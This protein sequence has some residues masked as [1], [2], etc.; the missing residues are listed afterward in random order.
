MIRLDWEFSKGAQ[1]WS[2]VSVGAVSNEGRFRV[3]VDSLIYSNVNYCGYNWAYRIQACESWTRVNHCYKMG[4]LATGDRHSI[5]VGNTTSNLNDVV[6]SGAL[7]FLIP[8]QMARLTCMTDSL[9]NRLA[10]MDESSLKAGTSENSYGLFRDYSGCLTRQIVTDLVNAKLQESVSTSRDG[11]KIIEKANAESNVSDTVEYNFPNAQQTHKSGLNS[12]LLSMTYNQWD[13]NTGGRYAR[14]RYYSTYRKDVSQT[15]WETNWR[16]IELKVRKEQL[17]IVELATD[18]GNTRDGRVL[19]LQRSL[20]LNIEFRRLAVQKVLSNK[21]SK[22]SGVDQILITNDEPSHQHY[23]RWCGVASLQKWEI[24]EWMRNVIHN[25]TTYQASPVKRVYIPKPNGKKR[26][27]GIPTIRDRCL[28]ALINFV[29]EP[30]VEMKSDRHSYG[31]R[32]YRSAKMAIGALRVNLRSAGEFYDKYALDADIKGFFDN[33]SHDWLMENTPLETTLR[34]ILKQWLKA[35]HIYNGEWS[36]ATESGTPQGG[37]ISPTLANLTLNGLEERVEKSIEQIYNVKKRGI[38]L[39]KLNHPRGKV[40][41]GWLSTNLFVVRFADD[42]VILARSRRM[43]EE[44]IKP[45]VDEFLKER[46]L[47]L[48]EE[49]TKIVS[50][51]EGDKLDFLGYTLRYLKEIRPKSKL[52]HDRQNKE[53]IVCYPQKAKVQ[54]IIKKIRNIVENSYSITAYSLISKLNPVIRG[55]CQYFNLGQSYLF[56]NKLNYYLY[57]LIQKWAR[58]KHPRWGRR[59]IAQTYFLD[60]KRNKSRL[61]ETISERTG[62]TNKWIFTGKTKNESIHR[63]SKGGKRI[64]LVNPTQ[65]TA[66]LSAKLNR[67]P[68]ELELVHAYHPS[69]VRL[70]E[71][72]TKISITSLKMNQ[73]AKL[74]LFIKQKGKC[75]MCGETLLDEEGEFKY[76]GSMNIHHIEPR[77][78]GGA[79]SKTKNS[80]LVHTNCHIHHHQINKVTQTEKK[81]QTIDT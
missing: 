60:A 32:K 70:I 3:T 45:A 20:A 35:G 55:W 37:I 79:R 21:G 34:P 80:A 61:I 12:T 9:A 31:F 56:R 73:T 13:W 50:I 19:K 74:K 76:D 67:I 59:K 5:P 1:K 53:A 6:R 23:V 75:Y 27:L 57:K 68:K 14:D 44:A 71:F 22:T 62:N 46:G 66:T 51:R 33:I 7:C 69:Y 29:V 8:I 26:P 39:G 18:I 47:W 43:I 11:G 77:A 15:K 54:G 16:T 81:A 72:A 48:S 63:E 40:T 24:V 52:F 78:E 58:R 4:L 25:P 42:V 2:G 38:Y 41:Y 64:E 28:Q 10:D 65:V 17:K 36:D 49:K 30:L